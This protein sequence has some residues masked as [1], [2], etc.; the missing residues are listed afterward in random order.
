[1]QGDNFQ[2]KIYAEATIHKA[3]SAGQRNN[4]GSNT[5]GA[6][7]DQGLQEAVCAGKVPYNFIIIVK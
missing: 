5:I 4:Y 1:M 3:L 6:G 2:N 7:L